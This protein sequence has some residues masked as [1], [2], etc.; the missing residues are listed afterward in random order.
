MK[1]AISIPDPVFQAANDMAKSLGM[2]R[3]ELFT[4][5]VSEYIKAHDSHGITRKLNEVYSQAE[6]QL[7]DVIATMQMDSLP[8]EEW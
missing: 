4:V 5:A 2:S 1:T 7:D 3:S 8:R 6:N